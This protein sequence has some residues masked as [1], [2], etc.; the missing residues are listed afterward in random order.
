MMS[1]YRHTEAG[2][3]VIVPMALVAVIALTL[4]AI[5]PHRIWISIFVVAVA[6]LTLFATLTVEIRD[7]ALC[8]RFGVG[9][10][11]RRIPL[12]RIRSVST[13]RTP[14]YWGWGIRLTPRGWLW[15]VSSPDSVEIEFDDGHHFLLGSD[16]AAR[17][18]DAIRAA[19]R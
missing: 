18:V 8:V 19:G 6:L 14:W 2:R 17:L 15:R 13:V 3:I 10:I 12:S 5:Q 16:E 7:G 9:L 1:D 11:R 4:A